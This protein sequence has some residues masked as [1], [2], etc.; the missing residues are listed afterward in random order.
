VLEFRGPLKEGPSDL[1]VLTHKHGLPLLQLAHM[2]GAL[3]LLEVQSPYFHLTPAPKALLL[4][5]QLG[6]DLCHDTPL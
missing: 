3:L 4:L 5:Q 2:C 1:L 6:L